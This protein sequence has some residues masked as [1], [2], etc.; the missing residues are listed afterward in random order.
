DANLDRVVEMAVQ[1]SISYMSGQGCAFPTRLLVQRGIYD[2]VVQRVETRA[3]KII[4]GD[5][6]HARTEMG[7]VVNHAACERIVGMLDEAKAAGKGRLLLGG[8]RLGG[9]FAEGAYV[10]PTVFVD[11]D[12]LAEIAQREVFGP[13]LCIS[14]FADEAE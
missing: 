6:L 10:A 3:K 7:P 4:A 14:P 5:P 1:F 2:E 11:V 12:P 8:G 13:V 9:E